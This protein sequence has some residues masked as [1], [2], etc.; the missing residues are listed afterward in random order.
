MW[1]C[2]TLFT[3]PSY[4][5]STCFHNGHSIGPIAISTSRSPVW[6]LSMED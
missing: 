6:P 3:K 2:I 1:T 4:C 5:Y